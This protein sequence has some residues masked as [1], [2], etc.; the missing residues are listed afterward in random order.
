M[1]IEVPS[2]RMRHIGRKKQDN[3]LPALGDA[4][5]LTC[6]LARHSGNQVRGHAYPITTG[7]KRKEKKE[8][9]QNWRLHWLNPLAVS[10]FPSLPPSLDPA[11]FAIAP[12]VRKRHA[13]GT[14]LLPPRPRVSPCS[15]DAGL[16]VLGLHAYSKSTTSH[17]HP[18]ISVS[19]CMQ[20]ILTH[21]RRTPPP[22]VL[23][24][25]HE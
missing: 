7:T 13:L 18:P 8:E 15:A 1:T 2:R 20:F 24:A 17:D 4:D 19:A 5:T 16:V 3:T 22:D 21:F 25:H 12:S 10:Q 23:S 9:E 14:F 6:T 11:N